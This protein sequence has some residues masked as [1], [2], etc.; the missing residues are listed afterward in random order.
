M[1][2]V[3]IRSKID[4]FTYVGND[5]CSDCYTNYELI[6]KLKIFVITDKL[7]KDPII[8]STEVYIQIGLFC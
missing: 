8:I 1:P 5:G 6:L 2:T 3:P 7:S 4:G